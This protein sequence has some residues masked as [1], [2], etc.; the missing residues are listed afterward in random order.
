M[1]RRKI[2]TGTRLRRARDRPAECPCTL[3]GSSGCWAVVLLLREPR[4]A[5]P[6]EGSG[7]RRRPHT[8]PGSA[9]PPRLQ[10]TEGPLCPFEDHL[11]REPK[12]GCSPWPVSD[13]TRR[14]SRYFLHST[15]QWTRGGFHVPECA[16]SVGSRAAFARVERRLFRLPRSGLLPVPLLLLI[17]PDAASFPSTS[18]SCPHSSGLVG[19]ALQASLPY[20]LAESETLFEW[21]VLVHLPVL[22]KTQHQ[23][24]AF[25][26]NSLSLVQGHA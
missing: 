19:V 21:F 9:P 16:S 17:F 2:V 20:N 3:N 13:A 22:G 24:H 18:A 23:L 6:K 10:C 12:F 14:H 8:A 25:H 11:H 4:R 7:F 15:V 26:G 5:P 1:D